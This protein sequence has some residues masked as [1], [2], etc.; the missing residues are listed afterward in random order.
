MCNRKDEWV[1]KVLVSVHTQ[2]SIPVMLKLMTAEY[3]LRSPIELKAATD[4][5]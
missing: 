4:T 1:V 5:A 2:D 3:A